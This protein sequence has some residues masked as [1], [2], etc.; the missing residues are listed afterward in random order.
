MWLDISSFLFLPPGL[1]CQSKVHLSSIPDPPLSDRSLGLSV[2]VSPF[3]K[4][5]VVEGNRDVS[6]CFHLQGQ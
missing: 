1:P 4:W 6:L 2:P 3:V 5:D